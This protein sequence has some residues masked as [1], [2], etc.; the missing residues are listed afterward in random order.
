KCVMTDSPGSTGRD[1]LCPHAPLACTRTATTVMND[2][3][4]LICPLLELVPCAHW[5]AATS[6]TC[7]HLQ[8]D[9]PQLPRRIPRSTALTTPYPFKSP[10][11][12]EPQPPSRIPKSA[13]LTTPSQFKSAG[14]SQH[15][16]VTQTSTKQHCLQLAL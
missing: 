2:F 3:L 16:S 14:N 13:A 9:C 6:P 15:G 7:D 1:A 4:K 5:S 10:I 8:H 11:G 12:P